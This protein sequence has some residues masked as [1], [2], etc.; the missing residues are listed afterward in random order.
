MIP[1]CYK[2]LINVALRG[3]CPIPFTIFLSAADLIPISQ[4]EEEKIEVIIS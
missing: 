1:L 4:G 2:Y 3:N